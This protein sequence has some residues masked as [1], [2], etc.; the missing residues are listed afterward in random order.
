MDT[1]SHT[2]GIGSYTSSP[3]AVI[4]VPCES[5]SS[6]KTITPSRAEQLLRTNTN[7]RS[8]S[9]NQLAKLTRTIRDGRWELNGE[10][11]KI[12]ITDKGTEVLL[13]G[14]HRLMACV[15]ANRSITTHV[16]EGLDPSVF[17]T[18]DQ[19]KKR[20]IADV[21]HV[22][23]HKDSSKLASALPLTDMYYTNNV[24]RGGV[25]NNYP[26]DI[27]RDLLKKYPKLSESTEK[28]VK[29]TRTNP[30][31]AS[32]MI[33]AHFIF[34]EIDG[35]A[36]DDFLAKIGSGVNLHAGCPILAL[37]ECLI[38]NKAR[39]NEF[40][41]TRIETLAGLIKTWNHVRFGRT[42]SAAPHRFKGD[43]AS[44]PRAK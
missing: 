42:V 17:D 1:Q 44:F 30:V 18:I 12:G 24:H 34:S 37:R 4:G 28:I 29:F 22:D 32:I 11:I 21:F 35:E 15:A 8:V 31:P 36:A 20:S 2:N 9:R 33:T 25:C 10:T 40:V 5:P 41:W 14:Q 16:V 6:V 3:H 38:R 23:G 39:G 13:D 43:A 27:A 19:N 7:N 26:N